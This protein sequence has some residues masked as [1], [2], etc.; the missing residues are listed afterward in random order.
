MKK[1][2]LACSTSILLGTA[3]PALAQTQYPSQTQSPSQNQPPGQTQPQAQTQSQAPEPVVSE[4]V[5]VKGVVQSVSPRRHLVKVKDPEG[6]IVALRFGDTAPD[7]A[8]LHKGDVV[9]VNYYRSA[10]VMLA[11]PGQEPTGL[12]KEEFVITPEK[13]NQPGGMVVNSIKASATVQ[14]ID[15]NKREVTLKESNGQ[16]IKLKVDQRVQNLNEIHK[17]DQI[18]VRYTEAAAITATKS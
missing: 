5:T 12:E 17:G 9:T 8:Q 16:T 6:N 13:P 15:P 14:D 4:A 1:I 10:A 7:L 2:V 11:K 3:L 18:V